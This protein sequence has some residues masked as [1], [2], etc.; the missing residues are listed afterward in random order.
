M[1]FVNLTQVE[2]MS[3]TDW[4]V[5][6]FLM[7]DVG[8]P[9]PLWVMSWAGSPGWRKKTMETKPVAVFSMSLLQ[10]LPSGSCLELLP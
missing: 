5:A 7:P 1:V 2:N 3:L 6:N 9:C 4:S 10:L 8:W